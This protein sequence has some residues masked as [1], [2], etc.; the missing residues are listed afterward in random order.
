M[1]KS[2]YPNP[3][4]PETKIEFSVKEGD[5]AKL[6]IYN[7]KGEIVK[8]YSEFTCGSYSIIWK[9]KNNQGRK[10]RSGVYFYELKSQTVDEIKKM[11]LL[12]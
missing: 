4:N 10:V 11:V 3:F 8:T 5:K 6:F 7:I 9:G 12:K 1:L 2:A